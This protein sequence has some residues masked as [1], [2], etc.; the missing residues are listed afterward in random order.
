MLDYRHISIAMPLGKI[1]A[2]FDIAVRSALAQTLPVRVHLVANALNSEEL[3]KLRKLASEH[4]RL[5]LH[6]FEERKPM[7]ENWNRI[8][9][10]AR[11]TYVCVLHDDDVLEK[12][13]VESLL[14]AVNSHPGRGIYHGKERLIDENGDFHHYEVFLEGSNARILSDEE[15]VGWAVSNRIWATGFAMDVGKARLCG[16]YN[17]RSSFG[18]DWDL[19]FLLA[20]KYGACYLHKHL[21]RYR[22]GRNTGQVSAFFARDAE[23][24]PE[25]ET[26]QLH[27]L[28]A[29]GLDPESRRPQQKIGLAHAAR[30]TLFHFGVIMTDEG[31]KRVLHA[32]SE[33]LVY[34]KLKLLTNIVGA[35]LAYPLAKRLICWKY[36]QLAYL[37]NA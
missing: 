4:D 35:K 33:G 10:V 32:L 15:I 21:G 17:L 3:Q 22:L 13:A 8:F 34:G 11:E 5:V 12:C 20:A 24:L 2:W 26:Q 7:V 27:N 14:H 19:Y 6:V 36:P 28:R 9:E 29:L 16:C 1:S 37:A 30:A 23:N 18:P 25:C 31:K